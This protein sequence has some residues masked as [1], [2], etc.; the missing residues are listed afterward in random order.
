LTEHQVYG[1]RAWGAPANNGY[2]VASQD[3]Q[4]P[5]FALRHDLIHNQEN[6]W[7]QDV[8]SA[9]G[10][11]NVSNDGNADSYPASNSLGVRPA[12]QIIG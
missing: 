9:A 8:V 12:F 11:A 4:L 10:F 1:A 5:G 3:G 7:L 2:G 6:W